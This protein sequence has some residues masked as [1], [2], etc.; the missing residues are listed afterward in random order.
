MKI[1]IAKPAE[2][3]SILEECNPEAIMY[4]GLDDALVGMISRAGTEPLALYDRSKLVDLLISHGLSNEQA[5]NYICYN[6]EGCWAGPHTP[7]L[8]SFN[9]DPVGI[10]Y[11]VEDLGVVAGDS[12][13]AEILFGTQVGGDVPVDSADIG[14]DLVDV[15]PEAGGPIGSGDGDEVSTGAVVVDG[16]VEP[17]V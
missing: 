6:I 5:E 3:I 16:D 10:R 9:L 17:K 7:F 1:D 8:A 2:I 14:S 12:A 4:D 15:A 13:D 11:P